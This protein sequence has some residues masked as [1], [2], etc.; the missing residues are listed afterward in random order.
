MCQQHDRASRLGREKKQP[1]VQVR[2]LQF[3]KICIKIPDDSSAKN[4]GLWSTPCRLQQLCIAMDSHCQ[5]QEASLM[6]HLFV[7]DILIFV[8]AFIRLREANTALELLSAKSFRK[9]TNMTRCM[10]FYCHRHQLRLWPWEILQVTISMFQL[11]DFS[12]SV[13]LGQFTSVLDYQ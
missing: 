12:H 8:P 13:C 2:L 7:G 3:F 6:D 9:S 1:P 4:Y 10:Y 5:K 11:H